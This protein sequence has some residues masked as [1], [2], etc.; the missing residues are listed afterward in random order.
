MA[1]CS[2]YL[3]LN[4]HKKKIVLLLLESIG[5]IIVLV[6]MFR[7]KQLPIN[8]LFSSWSKEYI[9]LGLASLAHKVQPTYRPVT[10]TP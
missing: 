10:Y 2:F 9:G 4:Q 3:M 6:Y 7:Q 5:R 1:D 8:C